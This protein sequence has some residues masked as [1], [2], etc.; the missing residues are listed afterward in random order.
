VSTSNP[1]PNWAEALY[2]IYERLPSDEYFEWSPESC[3]EFIVDIYRRVNPLFA[4][5]REVDTNALLVEAAQ[6]FYGYTPEEVAKLAS[7]KAI[8]A[9]RGRIPQAL[10]E[11]WTVQDELQAVVD[12]SADVIGL[13]S[14]LSLRM[15]RDIFEGRVVAKSYEEERAL[16]ALLRSRGAYGFDKTLTAKEYREKAAAFEFLAQEAEKAEAARRGA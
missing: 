5:R 15:H 3:R 8:A 4:D 1:V 7:E 14:V 16:V 9:L 11:A 10:T 6:P 13:S 12:D 2:Q